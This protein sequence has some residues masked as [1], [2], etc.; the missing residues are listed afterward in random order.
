M[1]WLKETPNHQ[2]QNE[3]HLLPKQHSQRSDSHYNLICDSQLQN[4]SITHAPAAARNL[5]AAIP[6]RSA[7]TELQ[8]TIE[9]RTMATQI[10]A[11]KPDLDDQAEKRRF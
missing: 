6:L 8:N 4:T 9:V 7:E 11:P 1:H 2:H 3:K 10:A 5:D